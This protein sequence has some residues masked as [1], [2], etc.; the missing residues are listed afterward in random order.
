MSTTNKSKTKPSIIEFGTAR[1]IADHKSGTPEWHA[2]RSAGI[3]GSDVA[4]IVGA[5][6]WS[7]PFKIWAVKTGKLSDESSQN[8]SMEWGTLLEPVIVE[9][10]KRQRPDVTVWASP[11]TWAHKDRPWQLA[12]PDGIYTTVDGKNGILEIKT[13]M[14]ED[15]WKVPAEGVMGD[16]EGVPLYYRTQVMWYMNA[17]GFDEAIVAVLF[18]GNKYREFFVP[19]DNFAQ[20]VY[21]SEAEKFLELVRTDQHPDFDGAMSTL[22]T[23][24]ELRPEIDPAGSVELGD[25]YVFYAN[26]VSDVEHATDHLNEMKSRVLDAM[27]DAKRGLFDDKWVLTRQSKNGGTPY[28]VAKRG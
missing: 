15:G 28:L 6:P 23:V 20:E 18:H 27:G 26:A 24:R 9:K 10:F 25:L 12:N 5:S 17:F 8:E 2:L 16:A 7:S 13:A 22:E 4:A 3:G 14:Y 11:G 21:V 1:F 19:A